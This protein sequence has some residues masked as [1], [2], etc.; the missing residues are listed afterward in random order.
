M[1][2][3]IELIK[4]AGHLD[5]IDHI[6]KVQIMKRGSK[7]GGLLVWGKHN[8]GKTTVLN[9]L[10][11]FLFVTHYKQTKG[12]FDCKYYMG[13]YAEDF[14]G[15][16]EQGYGK[17]FDP[18]DD[19][20][21]AKTAL[22]GDGLVTENKHCHPTTKWRGV[23]MIMTSNRLPP[24]FRKPQKRKDEDEYDYQDRLTTYHALMT[25]C[26]VFQMTESHYL[27]EEF[28]Y[29]HE[30][31]ARYMDYILDKIAGDNEDEAPV[32]QQQPPNNFKEIAMSDI[33]R[34]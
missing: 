1:N 4:K 14:L 17:I 21:N 25:R 2:E 12:N 11:V 15:L 24:A 27:E 34:R 16:D 32:Q 13:K 29:T 20:L 5:F 3:I 7:R 9:Y 8:S 18:R 22:G 30:D 26:A 6:W 10:S 28:P 33:P 23:P 31:L 19:Y